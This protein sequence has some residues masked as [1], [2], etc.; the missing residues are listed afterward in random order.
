ML[1]TYERRVERIRI[2]FVV[3]VSVA[4]ENYFTCWPSVEESRFHG[5]FSGRSGHWCS[6]QM[7]FHFLPF[8]DFLKTVSCSFL[9]WAGRTLD[10]NVFTNFSCV[11]RF[12]PGVKNNGR[13]SNT[14]GFS[15]R[16]DTLV[17][18]G[19]KTSW[20]LMGGITQGLGVNQRSCLALIKKVSNHGLLQFCFAIFSKG[21]EGKS[22]LHW[23][24]QH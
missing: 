20:P 23:N 9:S 6:T 13:K 1:R 7:L 14:L 5:D 4:T 22:S 12:L 19:K 16:G 17:G 11:V 18:W 10:H 2:L 24:I 21:S 3:I 8:P 15:M